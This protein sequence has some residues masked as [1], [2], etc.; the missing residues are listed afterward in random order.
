MIRQRQE[1]WEAHL[2]SRAQRGERVAFQ[3]L[4]DLHRAAVRGHALRML[5]SSDD[6]EDAVQET[7]LKAF[8][9]LRS[10]DSGRPV[11]P[12]LMRICTNCCLDSLR[13]RRSDTE[14]LDK[15][16]HELMD[17]ASDAAQLLQLDAD[18]QR[19]RE[20]VSRLPARYREIIM[21]RHFRHMDV[22][23][24][25][26]ELCKPEGTIKSWLF[27]ARALLREDLREAISA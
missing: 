8:K 15:H 5:R 11:L 13:S 12:W 21:M 6:A 7:F 23:E 1:G 9:A 16:E 24:I 2:V 22:C 25:A 14:T 17:T 19:V 26:E 18:G 3:L 27:R 20:A 10:F 4:V